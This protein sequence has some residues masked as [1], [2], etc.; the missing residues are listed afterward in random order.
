M[1]HHYQKIETRRNYLK[2]GGNI[3]KTV[4][5]IIDT[6]HS[7]TVDGN[8]HNVSCKIKEREAEVVQAQ[9]GSGASFSRTYL[10]DKI[11]CVKITKMLRF[12]VTHVQANVRIL[13]FALK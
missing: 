1:P 7:D 10:I 3:L 9:D 2:K 12:I 5:K 11:I 13:E 6:K 8:R 4:P